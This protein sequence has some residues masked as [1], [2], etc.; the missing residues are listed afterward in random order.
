MLRFSRVSCRV[1]CVFPGH[2]AAQDSVLDTLRRQINSPPVSKA[3]YLCASHENSISLG[4]RGILARKECKL[5]YLN[6]IHCNEHYH[7]L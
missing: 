1:P 3:G 7:N 4:R 6:V 2:I 5:Y